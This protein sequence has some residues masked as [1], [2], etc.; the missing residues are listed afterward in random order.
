[1]YIFIYIYI[2]LFVY[3]YIPVSL[4]APELRLRNEKNDVG[5]TKHKIP[6]QL[7]LTVQLTIA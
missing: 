4:A 7:R 2:Y 3:L 6:S 1:M 5:N